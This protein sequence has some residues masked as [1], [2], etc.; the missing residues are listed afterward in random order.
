M[1]KA[2]TLPAM[3]LMKLASRAV[4]AKAEMPV[5]KVVEQHRG[6]RE[7]VIE[8]WLAARVEHDL[9]G[10][11]VSLGRHKA[12]AHGFGLAGNVDRCGAR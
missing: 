12:L 1:L 7:V 8:Q 6:N 9:A 10:E 2:V 5:G 11:R 3:P 4:Q